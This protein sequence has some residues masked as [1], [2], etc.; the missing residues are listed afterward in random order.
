MLWTME[1]GQ[2]EQD[3]IFMSYISTN[4]NV[5]NKSNKVLNYILRSMQSPQQTWTDSAISS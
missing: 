1:F 2:T 3:I 4:Y 5:Y